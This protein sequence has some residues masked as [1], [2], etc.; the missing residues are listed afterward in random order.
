MTDDCVHLLYN[1]SWKFHQLAAGQ[2]LSWQPIRYG[3][4]RRY[5]PSITHKVT[6]AGSFSYSQPGRPPW[7]VSPLAFGLIGP[8]CQSFSLCLHISWLKVS[9]LKKTRFRGM[10]IFCLWFVI[11]QAFLELK[12]DTIDFSRIRQEIQRLV[13]FAQS[14]NTRSGISDCSWSLRLC[15]SIC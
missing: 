2:L 6:P 15:V 3:K 5:G 11:I 12:F 13:H 4:G 8:N 10:N 1:I 7:W 9:K 14:K